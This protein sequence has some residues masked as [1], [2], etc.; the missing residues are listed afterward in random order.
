MS[1][2]KGSVNSAPVAVTTA[3]F[4]E[5]DIPQVTRTSAEN[6][7]TAI[8]K[9]RAASFLAGEPVKALSF[10]VPNDKVEQTLRLLGLAGRANGV[11]VR[12]A[13][14][15]GETETR[16]KFWCANLQTRPRKDEAV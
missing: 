14:I 3:M 10:S 8:L 6:P 4:T 7:Y 15:A 13:L 11:T 2:T 5:E 1:R 9:P 12:K 16:I